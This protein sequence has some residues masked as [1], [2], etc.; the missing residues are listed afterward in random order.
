MD[1]KLRAMGECKDDEFWFNYNEYRTSEILT[2]VKV[3][4]INLKC[5][6]KILMESIIP[7]LVIMG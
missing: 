3:Q 6:L 2:S 1:T 7:W 5:F 4:S